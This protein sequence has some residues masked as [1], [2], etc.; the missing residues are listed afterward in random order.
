MLSRVADSLFWLGRYTERAENYARFIDVNFN[1]SIDLPPGMEEQ[2]KPLLTATGDN[3]HFQLLFGQKYSRENAIFY[4][5]F[6][7]RNQ[8]S[9]I[10]S[11]IQA[12]ENARIV[13]ESIPNE[14]WEALNDLHYFVKDLVKKKIWKKD[15]P[16]NCFKE[17]KNK[18][19]LL[20]GIAND[21]IPRTQGWYF[22][23]VGQYLER[24]DKTSR[25][26]DVKYHFLLPSADEVGSPL[27]FLQW[28]ALLKSVSAFNAY[29]KMHGKIN[30]TAIVEYLVLNRYFPRSILF[31]LESA[32]ECLR[33]ISSV[34]RGY[35]NPAEKVLGNLRA[36][37]EFADISDVF[38]FGLHEYLDLLQVRINDISTAI[39]EQY[40]RI[41]PNFTEDMQRQQ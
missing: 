6:E 29:R 3:E 13:R 24:A 27:D 28:A 8:N 17:I 2:W 12:R 7:T 30:P 21:N 31:C 16:K 26:L 4:M 38:E 11:I 39:Y 10:S 37:L 9:I 5:A 15:D 33:E 18:L 1:L 22:T 35:T 41:Q 32:E 14:T 40:F 36:D 25:I 34:K 23:K 19:Q 20:N